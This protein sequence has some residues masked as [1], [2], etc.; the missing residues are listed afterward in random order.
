MTMRAKPIQTTKW[1]TACAQCASAKAKCSRQ[2]STQ[3]RCDRCERLLKQCTD[4]VHRPRKSRQ[5]KQASSRDTPPSLDSFRGI[6]I[7]SARTSPLPDFDASS[8]ASTRDPASGP[9]S[10]RGRSP[11]PSDSGSRRRPHSLESENTCCPCEPRSPSL[12]R[13]ESDERLLDLFKQELMPHYPFVS[14]PPSIK[15]DV[16]QTERPFLMSAIRLVAGL[17]RRRSSRRQMVQIMGRLGSQTLLRAESSNHFQQLE[18]LPF[19]RKLSQY[20]NSL[21]KAKEFD[22]DGNLLELIT[23][24]RLADQPSEGNQRVS[25]EIQSKLESLSSKPSLLSTIT[26]LH[27]NATLLRH[28]PKGTSHLRAFLDTFSDIPPSKFAT[29]P[30]PIIHHLINATALL[31]RHANTTPTSAHDSRL[32][33]GNPT[34]ALRCEISSLGLSGVELIEYLASLNSRHGR[35][36]YKSESRSA[37]PASM[38]GSETTDHFAPIQGRSRHIS[39]PS[40]ATSDYDYPTNY[41]YDIDMGMGKHMMIQHASSPVPQQVGIVPPP[42]PSSVPPQWPAT[43]ASWEASTPMWNVSMGGDSGNV[44]AGVESIDPQLWFGNEQMAFDGVEG[45]PMGYGG[46]V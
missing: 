23:I 20:A 17:G 37:S 26:S 35:V 24:Q 1:G 34:T 42:H 8:E 39:T 30:S 38:H 21:A 22:T 12:D 33:D 40:V 29:L 9:P 36:L 45:F 31:L 46:P 3:S 44:M 4:Q 13:T 43:N 15:V 18:P 2:T 6:A 28:D 32:T 16:L 41:E 5:Q 25:P 19:T 7:A 10:P 14:A 27:L 11:M